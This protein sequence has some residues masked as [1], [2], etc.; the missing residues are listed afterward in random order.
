MKGPCY[1]VEVG[2]IFYQYSGETG[3]ILVKGEYDPDRPK[4]SRIK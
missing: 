4:E 3:W 2:I 1:P